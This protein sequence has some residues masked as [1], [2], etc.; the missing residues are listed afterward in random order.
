MIKLASGFALLPFY[1]AAV[2]EYQGSSFIY[3]VFTLLMLLMLLSGFYRKISYGYTFLV[4]MLWLGFW[5]KI[6]FH[7]LFD[8]PYVEPIG[9]FSGANSEW[10]EV[11]IVASFGSVGVVLARLFFSLIPGEGSSIM[12]RESNFNVPIWYQNAR[13]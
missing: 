11:L 1:I 8:Y 9:Y 13:P 7:I 6:T 4:V 5:S 12:L 10:D 3:T 2:I